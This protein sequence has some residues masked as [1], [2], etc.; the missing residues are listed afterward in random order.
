[1]SLITSYRP[2]TWDELIGNDALV[3]S[4]VPILQNGTSHA[5]LL[6]GN[7]G[8]GKT[9]IARLSA[10]ELKAQEVTEIDAATNNGIDD[11]RHLVEQSNY[12]P[13]H[14]D[15]RCIIIDECQAIT[16]QAW[17]SLLKSVEEPPP[18]LYWFFCTTEI[19]KVPA[20][21]KS[22]CSIY[23]VST[24]RADDLV[25]R[26]LRPVCVSEGKDPPDKILYLCADRAEGSP[27]RALVNLAQVLDFQ[28]YKLALETLVREEIE[29]SPVI[30]L[31]RLLVKQAPWNEVRHALRQLTDENPET[32]RRI[33]ESYVTKV[34]LDDNVGTTAR[35][36]TPLLEYVSTPINSNSLGPIIAIAS[37]WVLG[38]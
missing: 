25:T 31:T 33:I 10:Q 34:I 6:T 21:I 2:R 7:T 32:V 27:R 16:A 30:G 5:F 22:R 15:T 26:L 14:G 1:M 4:L 38:K 24:L 37:K 20:N 29:D 23:Q 18:W 19:G 11:M 17:K 12:R 9:T 35:S 8:C 28:D 36:L 3:M 13:M